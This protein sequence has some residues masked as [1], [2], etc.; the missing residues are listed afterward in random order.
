MGSGLWIPKCTWMKDAMLHVRATSRVT[1][2][3]GH[4]RNE[5]TIVAQPAAGPTEGY[6]SVGKNN[7]KKTMKLQGSNSK[8]TPVIFI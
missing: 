1:G 2:R 6:P 5:Q 4:C 7:F 3:I 8:A